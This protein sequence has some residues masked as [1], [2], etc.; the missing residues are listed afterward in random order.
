MYVGMWAHN[1]QRTSKIINI[2]RSLNACL[3]FNYCLANIIFLNFFFY[4]IGVSP[5]PPNCLHSQNGVNVA[6]KNVKFTFSTSKRFESYVWR[7]GVCFS[8]LQNGAVDVMILIS[9]CFAQRGS[10]RRGV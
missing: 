1:L 2:A 7:S 3:F 4:R 9:R 6:N 10:V 5:I 8:H